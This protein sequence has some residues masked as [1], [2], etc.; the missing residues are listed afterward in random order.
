MGASW[1]EIE[2]MF[3]AGMDAG[4]QRLIMLGLKNYKLTGK[5]TDPTK[6]EMGKILYGN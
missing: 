6:T 5:F 2:M 3:P 4:F 1:P